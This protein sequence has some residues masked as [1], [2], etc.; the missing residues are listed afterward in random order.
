MHANSNGMKIKKLY[1]NN[2]TNRINDIWNGD[3]KNENKNNVDNIVWN[4]NET[5]ELVTIRQYVSQLNNG[6]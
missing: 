4:E 5:F 3:V 6:K 2:N 1:K